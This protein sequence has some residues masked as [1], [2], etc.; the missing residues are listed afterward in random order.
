[1][2]IVFMCYNATIL[3]AVG[4][5]LCILTVVLVEVLISIASLQCEKVVL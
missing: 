1:M 3:D 4:S 5:E 2:S